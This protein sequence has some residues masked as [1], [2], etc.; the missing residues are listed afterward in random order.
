[1]WV[2]SFKFNEASAHR[3][4]PNARFPTDGLVVRGRYVGLTLAVLG[5]PSEPLSPLDSPIQSIQKQGILGSP[6]I[7]VQAHVRIIQAVPIFETFCFIF[8]GIPNSCYSREPHTVRCTRSAYCCFGGSHSDDRWEHWRAHPPP[9]HYQSPRGVQPQHS[10]ARSGLQ[11]RC[12][13]KYDAY[14]LHFWRA[15]RCAF[16]RSH[17]PSPSRHFPVSCP[18]SNDSSNSK[19]GKGSKGAQGKV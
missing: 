1:M 12:P 10:A 16:I 2:F 6:P 7:F 11:C 14:V 5:V 17:A 8:L 19:T 15:R 13:R 3:F 9:H 4:V 18:H